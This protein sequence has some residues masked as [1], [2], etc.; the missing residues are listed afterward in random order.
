MTSNIWSILFQ[1]FGV[2]VSRLIAIGSATLWALSLLL[3]KIIAIR[4]ATKSLFYAI[5]SSTCVQKICNAPLGLAYWGWRLPPVDTGGYKCCVP[6]GTK[7]RTPNVAVPA[8]KQ[9]RAIRTIVNLLVETLVHPAW[10][11]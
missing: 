1:T 10:W 6:I 2:I 7:E 5:L 3:L 9:R 11:T 8:P 4:T